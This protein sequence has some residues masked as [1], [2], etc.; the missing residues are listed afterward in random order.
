MQQPRVLDKVL[1]EC[2]IGHDP[3]QPSPGLRQ[4][5]AGRDLGGLAGA[6]E[7][8]EVTGWVYHNLRALPDVDPL[9]LEAL[10]AQ[11]RLGMAA[12][13]RALGDLAHVRAILEPAR[14]SWL[15]VRG[16]VLAEVVYRH[17]E[18]R[19]YDT[20]DLV[21]PRAAF[22]RAIALL[23]QA[24]VQPMLAAW[25]R[26]LQETEGE[27]LLVLRYGT[28]VR[29]RCHLFRGASDEDPPIMPT[30][31]VFARARTVSLNG[32]PAATLDEPDTLINLAV[33]A[34]TEGKGRLG[35]PTPRAW[36]NRSG[37]LC[38]RRAPWWRPAFPTTRS[39][40][41]NRG[42]RGGDGPRRWLRRPASPR[43]LLPGRLSFDSC[44]SSGHR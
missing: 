34:A 37:P 11:T 42:V 25:R 7:R 24:A 13:L 19:I 6:A 39:G 14:L 23:D 44:I 8:H 21:V 43:G 16:P 3:R 35:G 33:L 15:V 27:I 9:A 32:V 40:R 29:L 36:R 31:D 5:V 18:L 26:I 22:P 41:S 1:A 30:E 12:H 2:V 38:E 20:F 28:T 10:R 17:P 4:L